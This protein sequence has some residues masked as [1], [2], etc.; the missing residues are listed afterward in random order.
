MVN[1]ETKCNVNAP[2]TGAS[3]QLLQ[4]IKSNSRDK[5]W[6]KIKQDKVF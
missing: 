5:G 6:F 1:I 2:L 3:H 4:W